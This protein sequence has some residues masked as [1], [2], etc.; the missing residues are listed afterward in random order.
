MNTCSETL[1]SGDVGNS[2]PA[3]QTPAVWSPV[4]PTTVS[5]LIDEYMAAYTG[6]DGALPY[7]LA[8]WRALIGAK[9]IAAVDDDVVFHALEHFASLPARRWAGRD[10]DG[11]KIYRKRAERRSPG[12]I[13]RYHVALSAVFTWAQRRR[14]VPKD[15][16][17]PCRKVPRQRE[18]DRQRQAGRVHHAVAAE[19]AV[20]SR[21]AVAP[22]ADGALARSGFAGEA[23]Q[24]RQRVAVAGVRVGHDAAP[25]GRRLGA[26]SSAVGEQG[27]HGE[28]ARRGG[29]REPRGQQIGLRCGLE[30]ILC[31]ARERDGGVSSGRLRGVERLVEGG[32]RVEG[33]R[34]LLARALPALAELI[35]REVAARRSE[36]AGE[37]LQGGEVGVSCARAD[38]GEGGERAYD[39]FLGRP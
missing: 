4:K 32:E 14:R 2:G 19:P 37:Q 1:P 20:G 28:A 35:E 8:E 10:A 21:E 15:F 17:N 27:L 9:P 18:A 29:A 30:Q 26:V 3:S 13:N 11:R 31:D 22:R 39:L 36:L 25:H 33:A 24:P 7:R 12:T 23:A 38:A 16:E 5:Q 34:D 6:R